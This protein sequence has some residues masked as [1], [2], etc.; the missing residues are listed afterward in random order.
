M[1]LASAINLSCFMSALNGGGS[2]DSP[3]AENPCCRDLVLCSSGSVLQSWFATP[4]PLIMLFGH[5][6]PPTGG[7]EI[8]QFCTPFRLIDTTPVLYVWSTVI[9]WFL[10]G[11][12]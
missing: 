11:E 6:A 10:L 12:S 1:F 3:S 5:I 7:G 9:T 4:H 2:Q 8:F